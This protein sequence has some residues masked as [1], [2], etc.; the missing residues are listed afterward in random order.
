MASGPAICKSN[1][2]ALHPSLP[3]IDISPQP[4]PL[5]DEPASVCLNL[6]KILF[7]AGFEMQV[8]RK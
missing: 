6:Y 3:Q 1:W 2:K 7:V 4:A 5:Y 8:V